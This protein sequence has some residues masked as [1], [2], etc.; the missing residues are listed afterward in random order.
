M[1]LD[2]SNID[3]SSIWK[4][5]FLLCKARP[6]LNGALFVI[7][8]AECFYWIDSFFAINKKAGVERGQRRPNEFERR[9]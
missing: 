5:K 8:V 7:A 3:K 4:C 1:K 6:E 9:E 2:V